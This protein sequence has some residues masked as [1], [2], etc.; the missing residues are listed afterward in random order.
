[1]Q[2]IS[3]LDAINVEGKA[4]AKKKGKSRKASKKNK[5]WKK[6]Q[7]GRTDKPG[8]KKKISKME[9][10]KLASLNKKTNII[11]LQLSFG[12]LYVLRRPSMNFEVDGTLLQNPT[13]T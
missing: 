13:P 9:G 11:H 8:E 1:M 7:G 6:S 4:Q 10:Y 5:K 3:V 2:I 12:V